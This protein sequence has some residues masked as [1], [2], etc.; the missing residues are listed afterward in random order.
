[1]I[2][3]TE[4]HYGKKPLIILQQDLIFFPKVFLNIETRE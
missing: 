2:L 4:L 1:M 3:H